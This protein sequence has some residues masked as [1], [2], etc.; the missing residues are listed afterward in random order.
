MD[1]RTVAQELLGL[2]KELTAEW[3]PVRRDVDIRKRNQELKQSLTTYAPGLSKEL[4]VKMAQ[5]LQ[6]QGFEVRPNDLTREWSQY[7]AYLAPETNNN[8]YHY[9]AVYS[10]FGPNG[11]ELFVAANCSGRI[12]I[13]E[14]AY[15]L[16]KKYLRGPA[17]SLA[18]AISAAEK[19]LKPK[20]RKGYEKVKMTRG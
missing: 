6:Q 11:E 9:Y 1:S 10:F 13:I 2:A 5:S 14:R 4:K 3:K 16:T 17:T 7:L 15:D 20:I 12:G 8:K 19:H 18:S